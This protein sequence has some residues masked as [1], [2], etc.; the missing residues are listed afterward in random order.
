MS[1]LFK[2]IGLRK[3]ILLL[4]L[5]STTL[6]LATTILYFSINVRKNAIAEAK[7]LADSETEKYAEK[8]KLE[9]EQALEAT[10][11]L[12]EVFKE[13]IK[14]DSAERVQINK[15]ILFNILKKH[16]DY[17]SLWL[18]YEL[19]A[20]NPDYNLKYGRER[21]VALITDKI[22]FLQQLADVTNETPD[23]SLYY[24]VRN[25]NKQTVS[26]PYYDVHTEALK[27][28]LM[29]SPVTPLII[30]GKFSGVIG[31]DFSLDK[32]Q[33]MVQ[34]IKPVKNSIAYL[35]AP[36]GKYV[37]HTNSEMFNKSM[38]SENKEYENDFLTAWEK[39]NKN[40]PAQFEIKRKESGEEIY[41][42]FSPISLGEDGKV[43]AMV[44]ETPLKELTAES[45]HLFLVT[46]I[47]GII[48]LVILFTILY[49]VLNTITNKLL[50]V[51]DFSKKISSG[52][53]G[54]QIN[55]DGK[56]EIGQ[57]AASM[58]K[59][60]AK[61][62]DIVSGIIQSS[63]Q[64]NYTSKDITNYSGELSDG[65]SDQASSAE[66]VMASVEEMSANIHSN[67]ENAKTTEKIAAEA[68]VGIKNGSKSANKTIQS[69]DEIAEKISII[70]EISRQ[71][72]ILAL[73]AAIEAAR[74]GQFGKGFTVV[75]N[76]VKKLAER[77]QEAA[78][79]INAISEKGVEISK[80]AEKELADLV[81]DVEKTA[82][83][84][85]EITSASA[86]QSSGTDQIQN[87]IQ[88]L[89]NVAQKNALLADELNT[90]A[91][92]LSNEANRLKDNINYF[93]I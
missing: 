78:A 86:E 87:S 28:I 15:K 92:Q 25:T 48:G 93:T 66:E 59:M 83:L 22:E 81:P 38:L 35:I 37:S 65:S 80:T 64:I 3:K 1:Y 42:S 77:A 85:R 8:I 16:K 7:H 30:E 84:V 20:L 54:S 33:Q 62:R 70:G 41:V 17:L 73:N 11:T 19:K 67:T 71:T 45:D 53:L 26:D 31:I 39:I 10:N 24:T 75:A 58:N 49:F 89:N 13:N 18:V 44:T 6:V 34:N 63:D 79:E 12:S 46:I 50:K 56:D 43:W 27:G 36:N 14:M 57:L 60:T 91:K 32:V 90:K 2:N 40:T 52:D 76:E 51:L 21:N 47:V 9:F 29:V 82:M 88:L 61:L 55:I 72:N 4:V 74:A 23:L 68:A 5:V 69:I